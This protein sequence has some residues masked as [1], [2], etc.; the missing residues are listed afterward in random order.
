LSLYGIAQLFEGPEFLENCVIGFPG[1]SDDTP[2]P[3]HEEWKIA[4]E[5][6]YKMIKNNQIDELSELIDSKLN[7]IKDIEY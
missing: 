1:C 5:L 6:I 7:Y 3:F 4:K 2:C